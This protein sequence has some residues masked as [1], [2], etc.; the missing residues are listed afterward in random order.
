[1]IHPTHQWCS[2]V[3][4]SIDQ[5]SAEVFQMVNHWHQKGKSV[6]EIKRILVQTAQAKG[7]KLVFVGTKGNN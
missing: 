7:K 1:M 5:T 2:T 6:E 4:K 3:G